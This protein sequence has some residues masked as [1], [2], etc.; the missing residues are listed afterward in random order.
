MQ[1]DVVV[2]PEGS[3][4]VPAVCDGLRGRRCHRKNKGNDDQ[5][6]GEDC[7]GQR[8]D[9]MLMID[10]LMIVIIMMCARQLEIVE[11][12][13]RGKKHPGGEDRREEHQSIQASAA[14]G[15]RL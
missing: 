14:H 11:G 6:R 2:A 5:D 13:V 12:H 4:R 10:R 7:N 1:A 15:R 8:P 3:R 9:R